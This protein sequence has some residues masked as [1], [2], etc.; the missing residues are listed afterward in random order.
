LLIAR[1]GLLNLFALLLF[2]ARL[3]VMP[4]IFFGP[5]SSDDA[6]PITQSQAISTPLLTISMAKG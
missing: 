6:S 3:R 5:L 1:V 2:Y 4:N